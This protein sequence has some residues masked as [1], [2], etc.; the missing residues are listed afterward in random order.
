MGVTPYGFLTITI[1][2]SHRCSRRQRLGLFSP[3]VSSGSVLSALTNSS[4]V[5]AAR[6]ACSQSNKCSV[7]PISVSQISVSLSSAN[8]MRGRMLCKDK[9]PEYT[10][11]RSTSVS[12]S[13]FTMLPLCHPSWLLLMNSLTPVPA[14]NLTGCLLRV[15]IIPSVWLTSGIRVRHHRDCDG[16]SA[17]RA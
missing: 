10:I 8:E 4:L 13:S 1:H 3:D 17:T 12:C 5:S 7:L 14:K 11:W 15:S 9:T 16:H 6:V 2:D